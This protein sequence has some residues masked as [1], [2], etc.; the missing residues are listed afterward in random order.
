MSSTHISLHPKN[1]HFPESYYHFKYLSFPRPGKSKSMNLITKA[2]SYEEAYKKASNK[3]KKS[4][5]YNGN[6]ERHKL[7]L[8]WIEDIDFFEI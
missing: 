7:L 6:F 3:I 5:H 8:C 1:T 4:C 2:K